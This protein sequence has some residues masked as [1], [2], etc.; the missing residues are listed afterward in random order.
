MNRKKDGTEFQIALT[1]F[2]IKTTDGRILGLAASA[3]TFRNGNGWKTKR[4]LFGIGLSAE[5]D[6]D[7]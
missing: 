5:L 1:T 6:A 2:Q 4:C 3:G 7:G